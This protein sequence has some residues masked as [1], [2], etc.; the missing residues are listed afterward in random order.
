MSGSPLCR[1]ENQDGS[2]HGWM[3][4]CPGCKRWHVLDARW[5]FLNAD[6]NKPSF[7]PSYLARSN[8][9]DPPV[10][11]ICHLFVT[12]GRL[13]FLGDSTHELSGKAADMIPW[14]ERKAGP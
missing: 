5:T 2:F 7:S 12:D 10:E 14:E 3:F 11:T 13:Y 4:E 6:E 1:Q 8:Q 9:G